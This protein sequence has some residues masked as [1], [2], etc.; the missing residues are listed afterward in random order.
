MYLFRAV[1]L[2][3]LIA[4]TALGCTSIRNSFSGGTS[5]IN[6]TYFA[7]FSDVPVPRDMEVDSGSVN[8]SDH[9]GQKNGYVRFT[10]SVDVFSLQDAMAYNMHQQSW[11][12]LSIF[13]SKN[14]IMVF[15]K[16]ERICVLEITSSFP[17]T[18][19]RIWVTPKMHGFLVPP[20]M[21]VSPTPVEPIENQASGTGGSGGSDSYSPP[22]ANSGSSGG[23]SSGSG[24][25]L[26]ETGLSE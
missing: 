21:P 7:E 2:T 24:T 12:P 18:V 17:N 22:P 10:G 11:S 14:G 25:S 16:G 8:V 9:M 19:M 5:D 15:E 20:S 4:L 23:G 6:D 3:A 1:I 26:N 13:K